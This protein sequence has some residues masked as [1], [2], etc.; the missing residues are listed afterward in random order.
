MSKVIC[1]LSFVAPGLSSSKVKNLKHLDYIATRPG[2]DKSIAKEEME[3]LLVKTG[4]KDYLDYIAKRPRSAGLFTKDGIGSISETSAELEK[5]KGYVWRLIVSLKEEDAQPLGYLDKT[6]WQQL[7]EK[8]IPYISKEMGIKFNNIRWVGALHREEGHP[9]VHL[10]I[11]ENTPERLCGAIG[12]DHL[13][14]I[15][16]AFTDE[17]FEEERQKLLLDKNISRDLVLEESKKSLI[18]IGLLAK[19]LNAEKMDLKKL[20]K[21]IEKIKLEPKLYSPKEE[22][23]AKMISD[24]AVILPP[25]GRKA[26]AYM[27]EEVKTKVKEIAQY[28]L[29]QPDLKLHLDKNLK[30]A[31]M[32]AKLYTEKEE[33]L[34]EVKNKAYEDILRR[35]SQLILQT[36]FESRKVNTHIV[37]KKLSDKAVDFIK[38]INHKISNEAEIKKVFGQLVKILYQADMDNKEI[39]EIIKNTL[40]IKGIKPE[41]NVDEYIEDMIKEVSENKDIQYRMTTKDIKAYM[42]AL[43]FAGFSEEKA[44]KTIQDINNNTVKKAEEQLEKLVTEKILKKSENAYILTPE[45]KKDFVLTKK[46]TA[47]EQMIINTI[48]QGIK[49]GEVKRN[50]CLNELL[51]R[52]KVISAFKEH[53][54]DEFKIK[55]FDT[56]LNKF[57]QKH[58][59]IL[60]TRELWLSILEKYK[61]DSFEKNIIPAEKLLEDLS[62]KINQMAENKEIEAGAIYKDKDVIIEGVEYTKKHKFTHKSYKMNEKLQ[63]LLNKYKLDISKYIDKEGIIKTN[64]IVKAINKKYGLSKYEE[65]LEKAEQEY[66][67]SLSRI[68]KLIINGCIEKK[69]EEDYKFTSKGT[70]MLSKP[71]KP[72]FSLYDINEILKTMDKKTGILDINKLKES[73]SKLN[74]KEFEYKWKYIEDR[75]EYLTKAGILE[76]KESGYIYTEKGTEAKKDILEPCRKEIKAEIEYLKELGI[77]KETAEGLEITEKPEL[78]GET[79]EKIDYKL[80]NLLDVGK[81]K[82]ELTKL[83]EIGERII[84]YTKLEDTYKEI[85]DT[86]YDFRKSLGIEDTTEHTIK[87]LGTILMAAGES[88]E[89]VEKILL[90]YSALAGTELVKVKEILEAVEEKIAEDESLGKTTMVCKEDWDK[91]FKDTL[92]YEESPEWM[93]KKVWEEALNK[94]NTISL[95]NQMW[96]GVWADLEKQRI[97]AQAYAQYVLK[98]Q[99][100]ALTK[101]GIKEEKRKSMDYGR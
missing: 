9:H 33:S 46:F 101:E 16:K 87:T 36:A 34:E 99:S 67:I 63:D 64:Y 13:N 54:S 52:K 70:E 92:K 22:K 29:T 23:L 73:L 83:K 18:N 4:N 80:T 77:V 79:D 24:L 82:I 49:E 6:K 84:N 20:S 38:N 89:A 3:E 71:I 78:D 25:K 68:N 15:K 47:E 86:Y 91:V 81:G 41:I 19:K 61:I 44:F 39:E 93:Y 12:K 7:I 43:K 56:R 100:K 42:N 94:I 55:R 90:D 57:A 66:E 53:H 95:V 97:E 76:R 69:S 2:V 32:G 88:K 8:K 26:Y 74:E 31:Y 45:A 75:L 62:K 17:I 35:I 85:S 30:T 37:D 72:E 60:N 50:I 5:N 21:D 51:E 14:K 96:R 59:G 27:P 11:W 10:M 48:K 40:E 98:I 65:N 58:K 1:K 28:L